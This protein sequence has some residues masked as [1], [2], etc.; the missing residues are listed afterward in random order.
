MWC[1]IVQGA[2]QHQQAAHP[3][4]NVGAVAHHQSV[5]RDVVQLAHRPVTQ[6]RLPDLA[7][8]L[9][10]RFLA[11]AAV[12]QEAGTVTLRP[13]D[14]VLADRVSDALQ[15]MVFELCGLLEDQMRRP[16]VL[17][18]NRRRHDGEDLGCGDRKRGGDA[19]RAHPARLWRG[20]F[21]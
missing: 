17:R 2:A 8:L 12:G 7:P 11:V 1:P 4:R 16:L 20:F 19:G 10:H 6:A 13:G 9:A 5:L 21:S 18:A 15:V 14:L 3:D